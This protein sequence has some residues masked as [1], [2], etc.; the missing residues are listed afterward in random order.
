[1]TCLTVDN[2]NFLSKNFS[3][4]RLFFIVFSVYCGVVITTPHIT[5]KLLQEI[6]S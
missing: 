4:N 3:V 2:V 1:M 6:Y 5:E